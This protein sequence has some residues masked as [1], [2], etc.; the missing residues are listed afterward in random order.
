M[1]FLYREP[2][3]QL[4]LFFI[5]GKAE[6]GTGGSARFTIKNIPIGADFILKDDDS[7]PFLALFLPEMR[8]TYTPLNGDYQVYWEWM[9]GRTDGGVFGPLG[10]EFQLTVVPE[11]LTGVGRMVFKHG[12]IDRPNRVELN[13]VDPIVIKGMR[14]SLI[15]I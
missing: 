1:L 5:L 6:A 2:A 7:I 12:A 3:G 8:D 4:Y 10:E 13:T 14:L 9:D 15:H 11:A